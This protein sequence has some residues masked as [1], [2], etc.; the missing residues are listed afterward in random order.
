MSDS[1]LPTHVRTCVFVRIFG[2]EYA[3]TQH[4]SKWPKNTQSGGNTSKAQN[5]QMCQEKSES[6]AVKRP[7][8]LMVR[9]KAG[10]TKTSFV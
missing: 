5:E 7:E 3:S 6:T 4:A 2:V 10:K 8:K 9:L 1:G